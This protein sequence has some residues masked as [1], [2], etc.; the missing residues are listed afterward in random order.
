M[1]GESPIH[2]RIVESMLDGLWVVD[3]C[4]RTVFATERV[5][6]LLGRTEADVADLTMTDALVEEERADFMARLVELVGGRGDRRGVDRTFLRPDGTRV[7]LVVSHTTL[8]DDDGELVGYLHRLA[9]DG[10]RR[11]LVTELSRSRSQLADAQSI[12]HIGSWEVE[13]EPYQVTWSEQMY[14]LLDLDPSTPAVSPEEYI[15]RAL[16]QD[17]GAILDAWH[18]LPDARHP[19]TVDARFLMRD[20][21]ER[22]MRTVGRVLERDLAGQPV[23]FGGTV[24]DID[25]LKRTEKQLRDAV[26]LN[27]LMQFM[28]TAANETSSLDVALARL[29][30]LLLADDDWVRGTAFSVTGD[31][32]EWR[33][34]APGDTDRPVQAEYDVAQR[35]LAA[36]APVFEDRAVPDRLVVGFPVLAS[37]RPVVVVVV[38]AHASLAHRAVIGSLI[39]QVTGQLT[40]VAE[41]EALVAELSR[42]RSQLAEAQ[43]I[44]GVGSWEMDARPPNVSTCS[45]QFYAVLGVDPETWVPGMDAFLARLVEEDRAVLLEAYAAAIAD[46][47]EHRVD[48]RA[49]MDDGSV[50]WL[51]TVGQVLEWAPDGS[52]VRLGGTIQ[53]INDLK[54]TEL[55]LRDAVELNILMQFIAT[56]ANETNT[57]DEALEKTGELLLAHPDWETGVA[58]DVTDAGLEFRKV[59]PREGSPPTAH[60]RDVAE[61]TLAEA[62]PVFEEE[63]L[64]QTPMIGFPVVLDDAV[65]AVVVITA[66]SPFERHTMLRALVTQVGSQLAEVAT[67]EDTA[68]ELA[69]ARDL[70]MAASLAKSEFLATM[71]HEIRTPLNG[72]IGLN[73]LL[74]RTDLDAHQRQLAEAM[75]G[76]GHNLLALISDVLDFSRIEAGGLELEAV[77]FQPAVAVR[78]TV[79]LFAPMA[80]AKGV[81]LDVQVDDSVPDR[82][83]GD[84]SRF[85]QVVSNVVANAVKFTHEGS[86][87]VHLS[88]TTS[89]RDATLRVV[90]RDTGIGMDAEQL[91]RIFQP[92]RQADASTT[93]NF[94]G[95][96]LGLAIAHRVAAALGGEIGV[97]STPAVGS[98]F[99]FTGQFCLPETSSRPVA[100]PV[101]SASGTASGGHVLVVEDNEVNQLVAVGML[102]VLGYT[103]EVA[104]DGAA[105]AA[106]ATAGR[107]DAVLMDLQM[108]RLDGFAATRLIRQSEPPGVQ[109]PIIALTASATAGEQERCLAAGMT[110]FLSK[111]VSAEALGRVLSEQI[112][113]QSAGPTPA[114]AA[115]I[116]GPRVGRVLVPVPAVKAAATLDPGRLDELAEMGAAS[117]PLIQRAID[118]FVDD[119][120]DNAG[121]LR[122]ELAAGDAAVL[123]ST[124]HRLK[125]SAANLG[126]LRVAE[127]ALE[128]ELAAENGRLAEAGPLVDEIDAA[129]VDACAALRDYRFE[130]GA[131][132]EACT[133]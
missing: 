83:E 6:E 36:G 105:A 71:S 94:G 62:T 12:A 24:Q 28:A 114:A 61:R 84:P 127:L 81:R 38:T 65:R 58:F 80:D 74:L 112:S 115:P 88:A 45:E 107:F 46:Q 76:A 119:A 22:W 132:D 85:G 34:L 77:A 9:D 40:Q 31:N 19:L 27:T 23:R 73:D 67:R 29:R 106:R 3:G 109:V 17:Q 47:G 37:E 51:R 75:Q 21:S 92:F 35:A 100:R 125:G 10:R 79:E 117:F 123:R 63:V 86:V 113:G 130:A 110:G 11:S 131:V 120:A 39:A 122:D 50:R 69:E 13:V 18:A 103:S 43:A 82:L 98:T 16:P 54:E 60:E 57:L 91:S 59:G 89:G 116:I 5:A 56:A 41:R 104:A 72:V 126:A 49:V 44:A 64:P 1:A 118:H 25:E 15:D 93:R 52:P 99:W 121:R 128:L 70:A 95:T 32:L 78:G 133:A 87:Q 66:K 102:E 55:Q 4:A 26:E 30:A 48:I 111:P 108:P 124:A 90:V 68:R 2:R 96:G 7:S 97:E 101:V 33:P 20:G 42:S 53:D 8:Y 129:L 14:A